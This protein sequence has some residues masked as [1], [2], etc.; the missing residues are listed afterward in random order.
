MKKILLILFSSFIIVSSLS[1]QKIVEATDYGKYNDGVAPFLLDNRW[2]FIDF[3]GNVVIE[4]KFICFVGEYGSKPRFNEGLTAIV[5]SET[6]RVGFI[7]KKG[8][9]VIKPQFYSA[10]PFSEGVAIVGTQDDYVIINQ[11]GKVI[12]Q[13]FVAINGYFSNFSQNRAI[14]QKLFKYGFIDKTGKFKIEP[15]YDEVRPFSNGLAAVKLEGK[16]GFVDT[17][18]VQIIKPKFTNEPWTFNSHRTFVQGTN[19]KWGVIDTSGKL[20]VEP[21]YNEVYGFNNGFA[22]VSIM[23]EK[24][25]TSFSIID[26]NGKI[27][28]SFPKSSNSAQNVTFVSGFEGEDALAIAIK[29]G[30]YGMIDTKGNTAVN[31]SYRILQPI[32]NGRAYFERY[33]EKSKTT[34]RGFIDKTAK[35]VIHFK[36]PQF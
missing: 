13:K 16:W 35:E 32:S 12:A 25:N 23:D 17:N 20:I 27:V 31:F 36:E 22:V 24:W 34:I 26:V 14:C 15:I 2:G 5:D 1:A 8:E 21:T 9:V 7:N 10:N 18:G 19:N 33:D 11:E 3:D 30:K 4:P 6:E 28:K 29:G